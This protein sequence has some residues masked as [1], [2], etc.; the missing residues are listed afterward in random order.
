MEIFFIS[1]SMFNNAKRLLLI[2]LLLFITASLLLPQKTGDEIL[3][4]EHI[5]KYGQ[6]E[7][8]ISYPGKND[9]DRL[10]KYLSVTS[11]K[12]K[13]VYIT[14][15]PLTVEWFL[16]AGYSFDIHE[17]KDN[18]G[19]YAAVNINE[20]LT[21]QQ[22]PSYHQYDSIINYFS[23][24]YPLL[25]NIDTI[26]TSINGR[27]IFAIKI[28]DNA[29]IDEDE[30]EVFYSST[31][32]GDETGG[33]VLMLRL[34]DYLLKSYN[35]D[36][37]VQELI[38]NLEIWINPLANPDGTY[39]PGDVIS[40]P[41]RFNA[42]GYD[43]NRNF[44][45]PETPNTIKQKETLDMIQFMRMHRFVLSAN[46]HSGSEV[47]NYPWD[48][49]FTKYH[50][51]D[52]WF[53]GISR[54]YADTV[55]VYSGPA[56]MADFDNGITR[57]AEWYVIYGGRQ[58]FVTYE[59]QG[60]EVTIELDMTKLTP[61]SQLELLW[62]NN[63]RSMLGYLGNALYG[64]HG[65]VSDTNTGTKVAARVFINGH[66]KDSSH[67]YSD[68]ITGSFTRFL[69]PGTWN[70][71]FTAEGY[72]DT[73]I[74]D[75]IVNKYLR[76]GINVEMQPDITQIDTGSSKPPI[77]YPNPASS[78]IQSILPWT[79]SGQ[80]NIK[81]FNMTGMKLADYNI[82]SVAGMPVIIDGSEL[83]AGTFVVV[84]KNIVTGES[85]KSIFIMTSR[86]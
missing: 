52:S 35:S 34:A 24:T 23:V 37:Y 21:W 16:E 44:P 70:L 77:L 68:T 57:G 71:T 78:F 11:V 4:R 66:D 85:C 15:S 5:S 63:Y 36:N 48:R 81:I 61:P 8:S 30:P 1:D 69:S 53:E 38:D 64:V 13:E 84:F 72:H 17:K 55:H 47:V 74:T 22:Y 29:D 3:L 19:I 2:L 56:Y 10:T 40:S 76:T 51:D 86:F 43:L 59:L 9:M 46:F 26:G 62:Q 73:V 58:D 60:R 6:A 18:K 54:A 82:E 25:C 67:V 7:I 41:V 49:W 45:D 32:H 39:N 79:Y 42:N 27:Y 31:M 33:F 20:A 12:D 75:V 50:A 80:I 28:S 83:P 65:R 14:L